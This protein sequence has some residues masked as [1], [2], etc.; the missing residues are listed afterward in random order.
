MAS[1]GS[2]WTRSLEEAASRLPRKG[3]P[4]GPSPIE[5]VVGGRGYLEVRRAVIVRDGQDITGFDF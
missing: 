1:S 5:V 4:E 2:A 3:E